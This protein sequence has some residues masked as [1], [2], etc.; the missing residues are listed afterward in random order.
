MTRDVVKEQLPVI[1][2]FAEGKTIQYLG[3]NGKWID[4]DNPSFFID[5]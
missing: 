4:C 5:L 1:S 2:A 3:N